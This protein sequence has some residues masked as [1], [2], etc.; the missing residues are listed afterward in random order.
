MKAKGYIAR[1]TDFWAD[2]STRLVHYVSGR[3]EEAADRDAEDIVQDV[4]LNLCDRADVTAPIENL[5]AYVYQAARNRII[6]YLRK[7]QPMVSIDQG[8][9]DDT[10]PSLAELIA[11]ER[12]DTAESY[13]RLDMQ[14]R[15]FAA[16][17]RLEDRQRD[18]IMETEFEGRTFK[19]LSEAWGVPLGTLL[20]QKSRAIQKIKKEMKE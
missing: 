12:F 9:Y 20:A 3:L 1:L 13:E 2:N 10:G 17:G 16:I 15:M 18:I 6:D 11:D 4:F 14:K 8:L 5:S 19:E 7:K